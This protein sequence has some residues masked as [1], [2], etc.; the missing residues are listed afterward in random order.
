MSNL[1]STID[2]LASL[3]L[4]LLGV[5]HIQSFTVTLPNGHIVHPMGEQLVGQHIFTETRH[6][7][8]SILNPGQPPYAGNNSFTATEAELAEATKRFMSWSGSYELAP[9]DNDEEGTATMIYGIDVVNYP[10]QLGKKQPRKL[11]IRKEGKEMAV[12]TLEG[13]HG[14][15]RKYV[16]IKVE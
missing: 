7:S 13:D 5:W 2:K 8:A 6:Y 1:S 14:P 3:R 16:W 10:N 9:P 11:Q 4:S 15:A 12:S